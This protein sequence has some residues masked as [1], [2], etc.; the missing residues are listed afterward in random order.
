MTTAA[1]G[2]HACMKW[3]K[4]NPFRSAIK[5]MPNGI[6]KPEGPNVGGYQMQCIWPDKNL[7]VGAAE[8]FE[9]GWQ[10][11]CPPDYEKCTY[12]CEA[13]SSPRPRHLA[14]TSPA[15]AAAPHPTPVFTTL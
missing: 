7:K 1:S 9:K 6:S 10:G 2:K 13:E 15:P 8:E 5:A 14:D 4:N 12:M 11:G 3:H